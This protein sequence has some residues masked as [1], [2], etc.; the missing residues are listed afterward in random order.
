MKFLELIGALLLAA[1]FGVVPLIAVTRWI[2]NF[3]R[4]RKKEQ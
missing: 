1:V 3:F 2:P 4:N